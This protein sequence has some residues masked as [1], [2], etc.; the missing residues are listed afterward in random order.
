MKLIFM[1]L[2]CL[3]DSPTLQTGF[4]R[5]ASNLISRWHDA[6][7]FDDIWVWGIGYSGFPH[8]IPYLG[9]RICPA[10]TPTK[11][12]WY[13]PENLDRFLSLLEK[14]E[15]GVSKGG[16]THL[17]MLQDTF[18][19]WPMSRPLRKVCQ[20]RAIRSLLYFPIDAPVEPDWMNIV[21]AVDV[22]AAY[23]E[24]GREQA[25]LALAQPP[26]QAE[27]SEGP[28]TRARASESLKII[29]HGVDTG[30]YKPL[31]SA[32][33]DRRKNRKLLF[34]GRVQ[35]GDI[36]LLNV[37]QHQ[38]RKGLAQSLAVLAACQR[39]EPNVN[40]KLFI[41]APGTNPQEGTDLRQVAEQYGL[42]NGEDVFYGD[43]SF[44][45]GHAIL[46]ESHLNGIYGVADILLSTSY[47]EGWGLP[48]TEAMAAGL[49][50]AAPDHTS[51][52]ELLAD[53]RGILFNTLGS[54]V[55]VFDNSRVRPR[56][57]VDDAAMKII[58][59]VRAPH[60][61]HK[62]LR[63]YA[64]RAHAWATSDFLSWDRIAAEWLKLMEVEKA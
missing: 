42:R 48:I 21:E 24:Y 64:A 47:G 20:D 54:D 13:Q 25:R 52:S 35:E 51:I 31:P 44:E 10:T 5:V 1:K 26:S 37:S 58:D 61:E 7:V 6:R 27:F 28:G 60:D 36:L 45:A 14:P 32:A 34:N 38:K 41:N 19:L 33:V 29:P 22:A 53:D 63:N 12:N 40:F 57:D 46:P 50:V 3:C 56:A 18:S 8:G 23:C 62:S 4:A 30:V 39:L 17:W 11:Q 59:A 15:V 2:L 55:I 16:F 9:N 49:P 43:K